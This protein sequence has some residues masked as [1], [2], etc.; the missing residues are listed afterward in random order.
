MDHVVAT[1]DVDTYKIYW[2]GILRKEEAGDGNCSNFQEAQDIGDML[3]GRNYTG[4]IDDIIIY[5]RV[6]SSDEII[7]LLELDSCCD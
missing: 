5:N 4:I 2:D 6:L 3:I 1:K 7:E